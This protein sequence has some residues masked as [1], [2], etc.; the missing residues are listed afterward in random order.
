MIR[1]RAK[2]H[3]AVLSAKRNEDAIIKELFAE[4]LPSDG[5]HE[6]RSDAKKVARQDI[7]LQWRG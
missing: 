3:Y 7:D 5:D 4:I 2:Y 6:F 1:T